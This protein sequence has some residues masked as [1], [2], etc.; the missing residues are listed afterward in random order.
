M[1]FTELIGKMK[2]GPVLKAF[3]WVRLEGAPGAVIVV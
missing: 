3:D 1:E 2:S